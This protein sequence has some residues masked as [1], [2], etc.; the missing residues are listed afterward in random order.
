MATVYLIIGLSILALTLYF[1][2]NTWSDYFRDQH[3]HH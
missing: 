1:A 3:H 2:V